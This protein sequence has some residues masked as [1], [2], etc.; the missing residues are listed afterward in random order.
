MWCFIT[1]IKIMKKIPVV[2]LGVGALVVL[3]GQ[4]HPLADPVHPLAKR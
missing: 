4:H 3:L 2:A 1:G